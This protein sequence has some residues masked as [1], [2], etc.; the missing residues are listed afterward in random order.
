MHF[1]A[2]A[3]KIPF[4]YIFAEP[5]TEEKADEIQNTKQLDQKAFARDIVGINRDDPE[6]QKEWHDIQGR[7]DTEVDEDEDEIR[8]QIEESEEATETEDDDATLLDNEDTVED[9]EA[10]EEIAQN[11]VEEESTI[12]EE[13]IVQDEEVIEEENTEEENTVE[14]VAKPAAGPLMGWTLAVRNRVN[15]VYVERPEKLKPTDNWT[16][17]Y[18]IKEIAPTTVWNLYNK[19][20][21]D[22]QKLIGRTD[23]ERNTGLEN[24]R[25]I[26]RNFSNRGRKWRKEQ[27]TVHE[28]VEKQIFRPLGPG[29]KP[30]EK[31]NA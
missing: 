13:G 26:I 12:E 19:V 4:M 16:V 10:A 29:S 30:E 7:V 11:T 9:T 15:G 23:E 24:Y 28:D 17:E 31:G 27:D 22:R 3:G 18:H 14:E 1:H 21:D 2:R 25:G 8:G 6:I 20:K 5:V